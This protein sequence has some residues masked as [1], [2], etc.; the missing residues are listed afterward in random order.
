E[1]ILAEGNEQV[2][3][4]ERGVRSFESYTRNMV[5]IN[6]IPAIKQ[7]SHLPIVAD[8][9]HGTGRRELVLPTARAAVAAGADGIMVEV[10]RAPTQAKSDG[11]QSLYPEQF[12][13]MMSELERIAM[14]MGKPLHTGALAVAKG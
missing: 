13:T 6:A 4:C 9:S 2:I 8:P 12:R 5:D 10:H 1:Y 14:V 3:L 7:L 11:P